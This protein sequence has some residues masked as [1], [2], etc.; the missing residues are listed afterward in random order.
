MS[1]R[2]VRPRWPWADGGTDTGLALASISPPEP[3]LDWLSAATADHIE[4]MGYKA[5]SQCLV[6][7]VGAQR[8]HLPRILHVACL[9]IPAHL[10]PQ[11]SVPGTPRSRLSDVGNLRAKRAPSDVPLTWTRTV[12]GADSGSV[13]INHRAGPLFL[14]QNKGDARR[15]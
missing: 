14:E 12:K 8:Q 7:G 4:S 1:K 10:L 15:Q 3:P 2:A 9:G 6:I 11:S 5:L 13:G